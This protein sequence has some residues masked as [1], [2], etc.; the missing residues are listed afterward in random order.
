MNE[1]G[2]GT[3]EHAIRKLGIF[4]DLNGEDRARLAALFDAP[5]T[6]QGG[7]DII[8]E[9]EPTRHLFL[10]FSGWAIREKILPD[11]RRQIHGFVLPGDIFGLRSAFFA[12]ADDTV[13][14]LTDCMVAK[15]TGEQFMQIVREYPKLG[16]GIFWS[17]LREYAILSEHV[18]RIG[19]RSA[20]ERIAHLLL[21]LQ[22]R[23]ELVGLAG[24]GDFYMPLTQEILGDSL[25]LS[26]VHVNRSIRRLREDGLIA[27][28]P[29]TRWVYIEDPTGLSE[30]AGFDPKYLDQWTGPAPD[31]VRAMRF[32]I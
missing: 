16:G 20:L 2:F 30:L 31:L 21:E 10:V 27:V 9:S 24:A 8:V 3:I 5:S 22:K 18:V 15:I 14:A 1:C 19:R 4:V 17:V 12:V 11:G 23:L 26:I 7:T 13:Q 29:H 6:I 32:E 28:D 25:G